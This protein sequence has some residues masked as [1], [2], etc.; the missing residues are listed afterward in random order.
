MPAKK[1]DATPVE[2][3]D[4]AVDK[5]ASKKTDAKH[6]AYYDDVQVNCICGASFTV[7][8]TVPGPIK[9]E[10]CRECHPAYNKDKVVKQVVKGRLERFLE[11]QKKIDSMKK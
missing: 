7:N 4:T 6:G 10:T 9:V 2:Q 8:T 1:D 5:K 11:K 3:K